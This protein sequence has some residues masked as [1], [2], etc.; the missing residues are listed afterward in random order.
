MKRNFTNTMSGGTPSPDDRE[1]ARDSS[2]RLVRLIEQADK[3]RLQSADVGSPT[4][5]IALPLS[6]VRLLSEILARMGE[7]T[8][9]TVIPMG[10][11]L[12]TQEAADLL[13]VSR[14]F[15]VKLIKEG[16]LPCRNVGRHR[17]IRC[18]DV[19]RYQHQSN[20]AQQAA[21]DQ[22]VAEGQDLGLGY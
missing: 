19:L 7:G 18:T 16:K 21:L 13:S 5:S 1:I 11:E 3:F 14:P 10:E 4:E 12:T 2:R 20:A 22:L 6:A 15:V 9:V 8:A 17:R